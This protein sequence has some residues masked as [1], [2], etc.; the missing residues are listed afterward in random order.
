MTL[1]ITKQGA[2]AY[3]ELDASVATKTTDY[4]MTSD[5]HR[6]NADASGGAM[7]ITLVAHALVP[8]NTIVHIKKV[9]SSA[10]VVTIT[11]GG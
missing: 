6:I 2:S 8:G 1:K 10:N 7:T 11:Q 3:A 9:D 4:I 5:D